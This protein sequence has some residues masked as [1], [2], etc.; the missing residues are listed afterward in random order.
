MKKLL[1]STFFIVAILNMFA[2]SGFLGIKIKSFEDKELK[3]VQVIGVIAK[4]PAQIYGLQDNDIITHVNGVKVETREALL[5][6]IESFAV[7]KTIK[8][9]FIRNNKSETLKVVLGEKPAHKDYLVQLK[10]V[11][12]EERWTFTHD[13]SYIIA[14]NN[15]L[16]SYIYK[17]TEGK[18]HTIDMRKYNVSDILAPFDDIEAKIE[19]V[20]STMKS[21]ASCNC[22]CTTFKHRYYEYPKIETPEE[23]KSDITLTLITEKLNIY[24]NPTSGEFV[25]E[26]VTKEKGTALITILDVTGRVITKQRI[27]NFE[28]SYT[29][30]FD[31]KDEARGTYIV[32]IKVGDKLTSTKILLN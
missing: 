5:S 20:S 25:V 18:T 14:K 22:N 8:I 24:P 17:D 12:G 4:S 9:Q 2:N 11:N 23:E 27:Q 32:Q 31:L 29:N 26:L 10:N 16:I 6:T 19:V 13:K 21:Q 15:I 30:K 28:G 3:A 1:L 7:G